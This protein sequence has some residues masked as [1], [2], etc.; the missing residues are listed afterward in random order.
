MIQ[1]V[2]LACRGEIALRFIRTA[3]RLGIETIAVHDAEEKAAPFVM[4]ATYKVQAETVNP[5]A[6]ADCLLAIAGKYRADAIAPGYGPLAEN[7]DFAK[8]CADAGILF[9]G[10]NVSALR[11][12]GNKIQARQL[13]ASVDVPIIPGSAVTSLGEAQE[14]AEGIGYPV[15]LKA[16]NG[17]GGRGI[18][19]AESRDRLEL[20]WKE[21]EREG[22]A[23]F[24]TAELYIERFLGHDIRH[25][26]VQILAD[27]AGNVI[28]LGERGCSVQ[29]RRQ[30]M[31]EESPAPGI[32]TALSQAIHESAIKFA[33]AA[34][35]SSAG[36]V[37]FLVDTAGQFYFIEMNGR[38]QVEHPVTEAVTGIDIVEAMFTVAEGK[39]LSN[40]VLNAVIHGHALEFR[41]C[42][43]DP[44]QEFMPMGGA[45]T[46]CNYPH[47][48]GIR[49]DS[50]IAENQV[51]LTRYDSLCLKLIVWGRHRDEAVS[52]AKIALNELLIAGLP[53]NI[54]FHRWLID[55]E[56]FSTGNYDLSLTSHYHPE[57]PSE[58]LQHDIAIAAAL[59]EFLTMNATS[60]GAA[61]SSSPSNWRLM[62]ER[63]VS[64]GE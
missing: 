41:I 46:A 38:I 18:R 9:I 8:A 52:R 44:F 22:L 7:A 6:S 51:Q 58:T 15:L 2:L 39:P 3:H 4:A 12:V 56:P 48:P 61:V 59:R 47:G 63:R 29:R 20:A 13:A 36:T 55:Y 11:L 14:L 50:G 17:G 30:K 32:D 1:R 35:Y 21:V 54:P 26:E 33:R 49:I 5:F 25:V 43:E 31:V 16:A 23:A 53:T 45:I 27:L 64:Y 24:G 19:L 60:E 28:A 37:E 10:P 40:D 57:P 62:N 34:G 42:A